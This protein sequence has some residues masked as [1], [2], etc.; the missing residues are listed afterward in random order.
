MIDW[1]VTSELGSIRDYIRWGASRFQQA[2]IFFGHGTNNAI[3]ES[4]WLVLHSLYL[5]NQIADGYLDT[6][7]TL[8][9]REAVI[10]VLRQRV[11][12]RLP[13]PYIIHEAWFCGLPF[14]VDE[15]VL[16]PRSPI[17]ELIEA[18]FSPWIEHDRIHR[19]LDL[20]TGSGCIAIA[21]ALALPGVEV[22]ASDI[23]ADALE[24][25]QLNVEA[26]DVEGEVILWESDL[27]QQI[28]QVEYD[29]IV[30]NPPY[31]DIDEMAA[32]PPEFLHEPELA[33]ESG[34][35]GLDATRQILRDAPRYLSDGGILIVEVG[36]SQ[37]QMELAFPELPLNWLEFERG[38][39][40]VFLLTK[41]QLQQHPVK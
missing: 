41:E 34:D 10:A 1:D 14:Y 15:R 18:G 23:S 3:D 22:D 16:I 5:P 13:I 35:D 33:L 27:F 25:A 8:Q 6:Q 19:V 21:T 11:E 26:H 32:R 24:V 9:E 37:P 4:A 31:V 20:C 28:P 38:G 2:E 36:A 39:E 30:T 29:V 17:A 12:E 40:G 7:L